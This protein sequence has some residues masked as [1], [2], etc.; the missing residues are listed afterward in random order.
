VLLLTLLL[1]DRRGIFVKL[2]GHQFSKRRAQSQFRFVSVPEPPFPIDYH[3][4]LRKIVQSLIGI[5]VLSQHV[6]RR[7]T[8]AF[9][10]LDPCVFF[11]FRVENG[12]GLLAYISLYL[13]FFGAL[14]IARS[15][16]FAELK[17]FSFEDVCL[18]GHF[19]LSFVF[20]FLLVII[21][22]VNGVDDLFEPRRDGPSGLLVDDLSTG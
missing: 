22:P 14:E 4:I 18:W 5:R 8:S 20:L 16:E 2:D 12:I 9:D 13:G 15:P 7:S 3:S 21:R 11:L 19:S 10:Y 17:P 1:S 6:V